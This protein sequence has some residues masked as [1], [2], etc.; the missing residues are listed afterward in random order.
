[1]ATAKSTTPS[2]TSSQVE[3]KIT[4]ALGAVQVPESIFCERGNATLT[5]EFVHDLMS[6]LTQ[7]EDVDSEHWRDSD[8]SVMRTLRE[9]SAHSINYARELTALEDDMRGAARRAA[10]EVAHV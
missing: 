3:D 2:A 8:K 7:C 5:L 10:A 6:F 1:M 4:N 9:A